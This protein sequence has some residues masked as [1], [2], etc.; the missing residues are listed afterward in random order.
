VEQEEQ[1]VP[2]EYA[3]A[4]IGIRWPCGNLRMHPGACHVCVLYSFRLMLP[5][6]D[7]S[8]CYVS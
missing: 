3:E 2:A 7:I 5:K 1:A 6:A 4:D 8:A